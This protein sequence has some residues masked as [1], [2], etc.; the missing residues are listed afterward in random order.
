MKERACYSSAMLRARGGVNVS[1]T[2]S[3]RRR[4]CSISRHFPPSVSESLELAGEARMSTI[5][6]FNGAAGW[7]MEDGWLQHLRRRVT[8]WVC[9]YSSPTVSSLFER[10]ASAEDDRGGSRCW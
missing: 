5:S 1:R 4:A 9:N 3:G 6:S 10:L 2:R 7:D 8:P